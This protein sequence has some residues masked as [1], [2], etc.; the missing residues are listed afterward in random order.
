MTFIVA[1]FSPG[2]ITDEVRGI[3]VETSLYKLIDLANLISGKL[4]TNYFAYTAN[5][6]Y[7]CTHIHFIS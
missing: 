4:G 7:I 6:A 3:E 2:S 1:N 5:N